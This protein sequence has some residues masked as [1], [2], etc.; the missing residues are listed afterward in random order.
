MK[1][2]N[3]FVLVVTCA[4]IVGVAVNTAIGYGVYKV[5]MSFVGG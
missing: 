4:V 1:Q 5:V 2:K 3:W